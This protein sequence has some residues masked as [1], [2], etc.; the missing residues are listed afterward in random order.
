M[1]FRLK[2]IVK[3]NK[4]INLNFLKSTKWKQ[5]G[6]NFYFYNFMAL[7]HSE[8]QEY[9]NIFDSTLV[10][11]TDLDQLNYLIENVLEINDTVWV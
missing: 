2:K 11:L 10:Q 3:K 1:I 8:A 4:R 9:C 5:Y 6:D 7:V